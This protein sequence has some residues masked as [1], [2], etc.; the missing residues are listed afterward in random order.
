MIDKPSRFDVLPQAVA[1][2]AGVLAV[3]LLG[4]G[5]LLELPFEGPGDGSFDGAPLRLLVL[6][7]MGPLA[8]GVSARPGQR[9]CQT[10]SASPLASVMPDAVPVL[11]APPPWPRFPSWQVFSGS[12][13]S[14]ERNAPNTFNRRKTLS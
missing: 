4:F 8:C 14:G 13:A 1:V 9:S 2:L 5:V 6:P 10:S 3:A 11:L 7:L 12:A